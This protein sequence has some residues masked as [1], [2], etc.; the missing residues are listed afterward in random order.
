LLVRRINPRLT[1]AA[2][3]VLGTCGVVAVRT[4]VF[5]SSKMPHASADASLTRDD[6]APE[7]TGI[8]Q[9]LNSP[10]LT[11]RSLHGHVVLIDFWTFS[12]INCLRTIPELRA[13]Y[14]RYHPAGLDM[15]GV[16]SP[17]FSFEKVAANVAR[18]IKENKVE[19]PVAMDNDMQ[20][21]QAFDNHYWPHVYL[22]DGS[23]HIRYDAIGE[24]NG[25]AIESA[26]RALLADAGD[27]VPKPVTQSAELPGNDITP[28]I[29]MGYDRGGDY[30]ADA[31]D[32]A[33]DRVG[34][35]TL[36][37]PSKRVEQPQGAFYLGGHWKASSEYITAAA[38][39]A[40]I[41]LP[42]TARN[43]FIVAGRSDPAGSHLHV[44]LDGEPLAGAI[45]GSDVRGG[46]LT[47]RGQDLYRVV[48]LPKTQTHT[49]VLSADIGD[50]AAFHAYTFTFG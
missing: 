15:I 34:A 3:L 42:F 10:P 13:F 27:P 11:I 48:H 22:I 24:G 44:T 29:Y 1:V 30:F 37:P 36:P 38:S 33:K 23:G 9:W 50:P 28:E 21:W 8:A 26:I 19:W 41:V 2:L 45:A 7:I 6:P 47:V 35:Y 31:G 20:T 4:G 32:Y 18:A 43:V 14:D 46:I 39:D 17:E 40:R 16:H 12:C 5:S 49:L 25:P